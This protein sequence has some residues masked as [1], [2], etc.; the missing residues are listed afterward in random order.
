MVLA[1]L[2]V[3]ALLLALMA[4]NARLAQ[5]QSAS[6]SPPHFDSPSAPSGSVPVYLKPNTSGRTKKPGAKEGH[7][8]SRRQTPA[9][10]DEK[11]EHRLDVCPCCSGPLQR[12]GRTRT[13]VIEDIPKQIT[14]VVTQHT[15]HRDYCPNCRRHV[16]PI[17]PDAM[18]NATLG[19]H[20]VA[21]GS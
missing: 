9:K 1:S 14:P 19:H 2:G 17:V 4:A 3:E 18:P 15:I 8:G 11:V 21:L 16:E 12:C 10:I 6:A 7:K 5:L 20:V 13:R